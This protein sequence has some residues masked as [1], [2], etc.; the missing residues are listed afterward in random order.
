MVEQVW[1][2]QQTGSALA[3]NWPGPG[4][5]WL[6]PGFPPACPFLSL[7]L[8]PLR[9][10]H[11]LPQILSMDLLPYRSRRAFCFLSS[12]TLMDMPF[13]PWYFKRVVRARCSPLPVAQ[14]CPCLFPAG[15]SRSRL[16]PGGNMWPGVSG[17]DS[18]C[19][20]CS[21]GDRVVQ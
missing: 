5:P 20:P 21:L 2:P 3:G 18:I 19:G 13:F 17:L 10:I 14:A 12:G 8:Q 6:P 9:Q 15:D 1:H 11:K 7:G 16:Y 4:C